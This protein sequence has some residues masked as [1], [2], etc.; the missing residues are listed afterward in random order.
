VRGA[1][2]G[3]KGGTRL[4]PLNGPPPRPGSLT[5][6]SR[7]SHLRATA[8]RY[9]AS[10]P[11]CVPSPPTMY[12]YTKT[13]V[14]AGAHAT[15]TLRHTMD[16]I[17]S[18]V[19]THACLRDA[20]IVEKAENDVDIMAASA[21]GQQRVESSCESHWHGHGGRASHRSAPRIV[22]PKLWMSLTASG[23]NSGGS[24]VGALGCGGVP[25]GAATASGV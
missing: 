7:G 17:R 3:S 24:D 12:T 10:A 18:R 5:S 1:G 8:A 9:R 22:P 13:R 14:G 11:R 15:L 19:A 4:R 23:V 16:H 21:H 2:V 25:G 6:S 20:A